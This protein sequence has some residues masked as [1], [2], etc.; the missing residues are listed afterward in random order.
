M[1]TSCRSRTFR[2]CWRSSST[3]ISSSCI[4]S[5]RGRRWS[6][7][8]SCR[9]WSHASICARSIAFDRRSSQP[10]LS[11]ISSFSIN[12]AGASCC[13]TVISRASCNY[14]PCCFRSTSASNSSLSIRCVI[15]YRIIIGSNTASCFHTTWSTS[16]GIATAN[17]SGI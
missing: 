1:W 7:I 14:C 17:S 11:S 13:T 2:R 15:F 16:W 4:C 6:R 8:S 10:V 5:S 9:I 3:R 12:I